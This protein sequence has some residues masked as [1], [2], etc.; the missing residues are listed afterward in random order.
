M[1]IITVEVEITALRLM[2]LLSSNTCLTLAVSQLVESLPLT[3]LHLTSK[4][5]IT[6]EEIRIISNCLLKMEREAALLPSSRKE[7]KLFQPLTLTKIVI[8]TDNLL[9][10]M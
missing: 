10:A 6:L 7:Y 3:L 5:S 1:E 4:C 2:E 8:N 9:A